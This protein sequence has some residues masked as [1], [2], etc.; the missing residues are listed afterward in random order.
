MLMWVKGHQGVKGN[1][2]ADRRAGMEA[3]MA[4][5][6]QKIVIATPAGSK[7]EFPIYLKAPAHLKWS[8]KAVKG[9][10]YMVTDK[11]LQLGDLKARGTMVCMRWLDTA[12]RHTSA[13]MPLDR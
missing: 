10:V 9:L 5:R 12:E 4:R 13:R 7:Q 2:E 11:G 3:E 8:S 1:E 6:L